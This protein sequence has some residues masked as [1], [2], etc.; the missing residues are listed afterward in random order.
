M[1]PN[2]EPRTL[3]RQNFPTAWQTVIF[4]NFRMAPNEN[5]AKILSCTPEDV[6]REALRMGLRAG[7]TDPNW[8]T[9]G[10]ITII[11][12][13]WLLLPYDQ[14][15]TLVAMDD[16][17]F[18]FVIN[19]EDFLWYKLGKT[20]PEREPIYYSPLTEAEIKATEEIAKVVSK[21]DTSE[22]KMFDFFT[23][24]EDTEPKYVVSQSGGTRI[25]HGFLTT[26]GDAFIE[27]TREQM[28][29]SLLDEYARNGV[30]ALF[31]HG[32]LSTL[33]PYPFDPELSRDYKVRRENLRDL[34]RRA[35]LRGIKIYL[36]FN[37]PRALPLDVYERWEDKEIGGGIR[38][39][40]ISLCLQ[41]ESARSYLYNAT[42][43]LFE[44]VKG[45]GGI[46]T[47][48]ASENYTNCYS[49]RVCTCPRCMDTPPEELYI[50]ASNIMHEAIRDAGS[51]AEVIAYAWG[52]H[53]YFGE[54]SVERAF[55]LLHPEIAVMQV[56][57]NRKKISKGGLESEIGEYS[58]SNPGPSDV[59]KFIFDTAAKYGHKVYA[60]VQ[61][62]NSWEFSAVPYLPVFDLQLEHL[63]NLHKIGVDNCMLTWTLGG[64]PSI[65]YDMISEYMSNPDSF[66]IDNWYQKQFGDRGERVHA[67]IKKF[68]EG[69]REYPFCVYTLYNSPKNLG[70]ANLWS[71]TPNDNPS[72]MV[73]Y[74]FDDIVY[75]TAPYPVDVY[76]SQFEKL[77]TAWDEACKMLEAVAT[78][79]K[80]QELLLFARF[81]TLQ[82]R[83]DVI[84]TNYA[85]CKKELPNKKNEMR[86]IFAQEREITK[87]LLELMEKSTLIG[88][89]TSNHYFFTE[90]G[91]IEKLV[92]LDQLEEEL[93]TL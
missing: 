16:E 88:F 26:C 73:C 79:E 30:N 24:T 55:K 2:T 44:D 85:L 17:R 25:V 89:E 56:S 62:C 42:K 34:I 33:S 45:I 58:I 20:K 38:D 15:Q 86:E 8:L 3:E 13:N 60:K 71:L 12:N 78:D 53:G 49:A 92:Q 11:R 72:S 68:C 66:N 9:R 59:S 41:T 61:V 69:F 37:E 28:P 54:E 23:D 18:D 4:R 57:E 7:E 32:V 81:A 51:D 40:Y 47:I 67:A 84:H 50:A 75:W 76:L 22:R 10:Y 36:Y 87:Q 1:L 52:W 65:T 83:S 43:D 74:A 70:P 80:T 27:D 64:Y 63:E 48:S 93:N 6:E 29:D 82:L 19:K 35:A 14:I 5:I 90:R 46:F 21:F 77:L 91:Y 39:G 31:V